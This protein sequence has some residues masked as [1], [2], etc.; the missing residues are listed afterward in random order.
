MSGRT[1]H[2]THHL[3]H[4][5][6]HISHITCHMSRHTSHVTCHTGNSLRSPGQGAEEPEG[7]AEEVQQHPSAS[8]HPLDLGKFWELCLF[9]ILWDFC[10]V[11]SQMIK[12]TDSC[13]RGLKRSG[14]ELSKYHRR[15]CCQILILAPAKGA[16]RRNHW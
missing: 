4:I 5:T 10:N 3:S 14:T 16:I 11:F 2:V 12:S 1:S 15:D 9:F 13:T 8:S 7:E 6:C